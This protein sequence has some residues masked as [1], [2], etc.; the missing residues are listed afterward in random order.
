[1][2]FENTASVPIGGDINPVDNSVKFKLNYQSLQGES[3]LTSARTK[4][5]VFAAGE[6]SDVDR[7]FYK[8]RTDRRTGAESIKSIAAST[9]LYYVKVLLP[10][11][12]STIVIIQENIEGWPTM[13]ASVTLYD[14]NCVKLLPQAATVTIAD[15]NITIDFVAGAAER[16]IFISVN[17]T[18]KPIIGQVV[19]KPYPAVEYLFK[20][21]LKGEEPFTADS[22]E[23]VYSP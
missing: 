8:V 6:A 21:A 17:Y 15:G 7:L 4:C 5:S 12:A 2:I 9:F 19:T 10:A 16:V 3:Q 20:A 18:S 23:L 14:E 13:G 22:L 1:M 11:K